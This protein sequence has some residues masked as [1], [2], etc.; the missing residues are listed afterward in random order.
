M[1]FYSALSGQVNSSSNTGDPTLSVVD[2]LEVGENNSSSNKSLEAVRGGWGEAVL[3]KIALNI[4]SSRAK[5]LLATTAPASS[6]S[7]DSSGGQQ[8]PDAPHFVEQ[9]KVAQDIFRQVGPFS[10]DFLLCIE[11]LV[12]N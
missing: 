4:F 8:E 5:V 11:L 6:V 7:E 12:H 2:L 10:L 1:S 9:H 3:S